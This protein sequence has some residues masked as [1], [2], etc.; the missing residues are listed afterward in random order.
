MPEHVHTMIASPPKY[1]VSKV[2]YIKRKSWIHMARAYG[3]RRRDFVEKH[4]LTRDISSRPWAETK[5]CPENTSATP[6]PFLSDSSKRRSVR[7]VGR[8]RC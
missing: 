6:R 3:Q 1:T 8:M 5:R 4:F 7:L 2:G